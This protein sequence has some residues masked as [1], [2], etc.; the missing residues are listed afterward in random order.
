MPSDLLRSSCRRNLGDGRL[1]AAVWGH[2]LNRVTLITYDD[3]VLGKAT[4]HRNLYFSGN[5]PSLSMGK[6][7]RRALLPGTFRCESEHYLDQQPRTGG[8]PVRVAKKVFCTKTESLPRL[9]CSRN[10]PLS[11]V[12]RVHTAGRRARRQPYPPPLHAERTRSKNWPRH[13]FEAF[14]FAI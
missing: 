9:S 4:T 3:I 11:K 7:N 6:R 1:P 2:L 5:R 8:L 12:S 14:V 10:P 13:C